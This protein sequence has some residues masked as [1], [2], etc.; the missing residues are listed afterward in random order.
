M[1]FFSVYVGGL[2]NAYRWEDSGAY[3]HGNPPGRGRR[4]ERKILQLNFWRPGDELL[5]DERE[6]RYGV[7]LGKSQLYDV[8]D[9]VAHRW[10]YR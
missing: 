9:G 2:T 10:V 1:D 6:I 5:L 7:P 8:A 3:Q 4:F